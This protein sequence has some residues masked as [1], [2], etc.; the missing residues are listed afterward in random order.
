MP[1][2]QPSVPAPRSN[3]RALRTRTSR[4][5]KG[6]SGVSRRAAPATNGAANEVPLWTTMPSRPAVRMRS[7]GA[8]SATWSPRVVK[9][10]GRPSGPTAPTAI[11]PGSAAGR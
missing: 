1:A 10:D 2:P 9:R 11:T 6:D 4:T 5:S 3:G 7:P 8:D